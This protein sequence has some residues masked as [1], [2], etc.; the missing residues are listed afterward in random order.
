MDPK[1]EVLQIL[2]EFQKGYDKREPDKAKEFVERLFLPG[3]EVSIIGTSATSTED[4]EWCS[5][6]E[7]VIKIIEYDW[8]Y[9]G[10][11]VLNLEEGIFHVDEG[12]AYIGL[13]GFIKERIKKEEYFDK[14]MGFIKTIIEE[15]KIS[16]QEKLLEIIKGASTALEE[17]QKGENYFWPIRLTFILEK[18]EDE[19]KIRHIHFSYP[20][21]GYPQ[22][23]VK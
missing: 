5:N 4:V 14:T 20:I 16:H 23:R 18:K 6:R 12:K 13:M 8:K 15:G 17:T 11:L 21:T 2:Q 3:E 22:V 10:D 1:E 19:W 7:K 9:W